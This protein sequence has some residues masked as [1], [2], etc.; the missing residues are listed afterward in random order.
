MSLGPSGLRNDHA[1]EVKFADPRLFRLHVHFRR[2]GTPRLRAH[3]GPH[4]RTIAAGIGQTVL[5]GIDVWMLRVVESLPHMVRFCAPFSEIAFGHR[6]ALT[7]GMARISSQASHNSTERIQRA[8][9][10]VMLPVLHLDP[11]SRAA[12]DTFFVRAIA[13]RPDRARQNVADIE[14]G[15]RAY[16]DLRQRAV[17]CR[18]PRRRLRRARAKGRCIG[19]AAIREKWFRNKINSSPGAL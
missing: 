19:A 4:S 10:C 11:M 16:A 12:G 2:A 5:A 7:A 18:L 3:D 1:D 13:K 8:I 15:R 17:Q 14:Q 9:E 6:G